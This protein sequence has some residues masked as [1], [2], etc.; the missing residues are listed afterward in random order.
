MGMLEATEEA[1]S[2]VPARIAAS[3]RIFP[4]RIDA[5][6]RLVVAMEEPDEVDVLDELSLALECVVMGERV[7]G[8]AI[9]EAIRTH[10]GVGADT[11]EKL[12]HNRSIPATGD[13]TAASDASIDDVSGDASIVK[14]VN[15]L[16]VDAFNCRATDI[17]LEPFENKLRVRHRVDGILFDAHIPVSVRHFREAITSRIK[18]M[19]NLDITE[20]RLPQDGRIRVRLGNQDFDLRVSVIPIAHG[21]SVDIR[22]LQRSNVFLGMESLGFRDDVLNVLYGLLRRPHGIVL[23]TGPTGSGKTTTLY[24]F[25]NHLNSTDRKI[26]TIEDP[27]EYQIEGIC[28]MQVRPEIGFTFAMGLRSMLRHDPDVMMVGEIRDFETAELAIRCALTGHLVFSTLHT[29]DA[30]GAAPRLTD[31]G[32][33]P[34]LLSSSV[35]AV[36][37]QRLVRRV[38]PECARP[39]TPKPEALAEMGLSPDVSTEGSLKGVGCE[40]CRNSG[41][42]GRAAIIEMIVF[43]DEIRQLIMAKA[44][45]TELKRV[46]VKNGMRTLRLDGWDKV[47][48]GVTTVDEVL[49]VTQQ[50]R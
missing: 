28:Q 13:A 49:R 1:L 31:I 44:P 42:Y 39:Y 9:I 43:E 10:Y 19:A 6:G 16:I 3:Y 23:L 32:I 22:I 21:E 30:A 29:N 26:I 24:S 40:L 36:L 37:A 50:D 47:K 46:A 20:R 2:R 4:I 15:Q 17:H 8:D 27:V 18:I 25:L 14:F 45:G 33:E 12:M 7:A 41:Y 34:Y 11:L 35:D 5:D 38:C 48:Q